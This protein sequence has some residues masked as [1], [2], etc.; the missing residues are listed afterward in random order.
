MKK[1]ERSN[2]EALLISV[3]GGKGGVGKSMVAGNLAVHYA[4]AGLRVVA[5]DL[6]FGAANLHTVFG[7]RQSEKGL[8]KFLN[9]PRA[10]LHDYLTSTSLEGLFIASGQGFHSE[11]ANL[12]YPQKVKLV[13]QIK[14]LDV[15]IVLLDLGAGSTHNIV[16][17]FSLTDAGLVVASPEPTS[18]INAFEFL[19]N[20][21]YRALLRTFRHDE[22]MLKRLASLRENQQGNGFSTIGDLLK[23]LKEERSPLAESIEDICD[24][25]NL[26]LVLNQVRKT[27]DSLICSKLHGIVQKHLNLYLNCPG[28]LFFDEEIPQSIHRM[29]PISLHSPQSLSAQGLNR[30]AGNLVRHLTHKTVHGTIPAD[31]NEQLAMISKIAK[32]DYPLHLMGQKKFSRER[33]ETVSQNPDMMAEVDSR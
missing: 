31:F 5:I 14:K 15:D 28:I 2:E 7:I 16:D 23:Q 3:G 33:F 27:S 9:T 24:D 12:K 17:F 10:D 4:Q 20:V 19:K 22:E 6:D 26:F 25:L 29:S 18:I 30:I 11:Q 21:I 1:A 32:R 13:R 8:L